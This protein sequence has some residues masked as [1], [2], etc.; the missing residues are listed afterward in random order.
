MT[1]DYHYIRAIA[2]LLISK[3]ILTEEECQEETRRVS[4]ESSQSMKE[5]KYKVPYEEYKKKWEQKIK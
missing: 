2:N 1:Y 3:G 5:D 4:Y